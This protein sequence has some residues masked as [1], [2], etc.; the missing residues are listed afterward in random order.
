[1]ELVK[2]RHAEGVTAAAQAQIRRL[3]SSRPSGFEGFAS[4]I[5]PRPALLRKRLEMTGRTFRSPNMRPSRW[6]SPRPSL[7]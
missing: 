4:Q 5:I 3:M 6:A 1:M 2:E 7:F